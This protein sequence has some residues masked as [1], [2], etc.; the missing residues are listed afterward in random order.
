MHLDYL[1]INPVKHG[2]IK[3]PTDW[4]WSSFHR[5]VPGGEYENDWRGH[6]NI[7]RGASYVGRLI[8]RARL[9]EQHSCSPYSL[10]RPP[11]PATIPKLGNL[12]A[13]NS[14]KSFER[15]FRL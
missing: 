9:G 12:G 10:D 15:P 2:L 13:N 7:P 8:R 14:G 3:F 4:P 1:H 6:V 5:Y 11:H